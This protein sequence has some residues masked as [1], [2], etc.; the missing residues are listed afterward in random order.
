MELNP[1]I[2]YRFMSKVI[3]TGN[4]WEWTSLKDKDGY[5]RFWLNGKKPLAHRISYELFKET[6]PQGLQLDHLCKN[7]ACVNPEHL[8]AVTCKENIRRGLTGT[9]PNTGSFNRNKTHCPQGH[10][11]TKENTLKQKNGRYCRKCHQIKHRIRYK[12]NKLKL[13]GVNI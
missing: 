5:G 1:K 3:K 13:K 12:N 6:I 2:I 11:Y 9:S 4:C 8:E 7:H 10:E